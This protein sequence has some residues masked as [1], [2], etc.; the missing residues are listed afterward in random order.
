MDL[1]EG[2]YCNPPLL[3]LKR[4]LPAASTVPAAAAST[5]VRLEL[6]AAQ[7]MA[8][9]AE[10]LN[11]FPTTPLPD[12]HHHLPTIPLPLVHINKLLFKVILLVRFAQVCN[13]GLH[14]SNIAK[15]SL[16]GLKSNSLK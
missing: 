16:K 6:A 15:D 13:C 14:F 1:T 3:W 12:C 11:Q 4:L 2:H 8:T 5:A 7:A 9:V 10:Y